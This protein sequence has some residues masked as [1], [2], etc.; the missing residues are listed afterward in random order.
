[1][2]RLATIS[3]FCFLFTQFLLGQNSKLSLGLVGSIDLNKYY[4]EDTGFDYEYNPDLGYSFGL[5]LQYFVFNKAFLNSGLSYISQGYM[6]KY[7]LIVMDPGDPAIPRESN[8]QVSF[9]NIPVTFGYTIVDVEKFRINPSVGI[10]FTFRIG[11]NESTVYEDDSERESDYLSQ[12]LSNTLIILKVSVG[13]EY[14]LN[15]RYKISF[16]PYFGK[17]LN[18]LDAESMKT[19]QLTYGSVFGFY[20][21]F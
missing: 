7:N 3:I 13:F 6:L 12:D 8:L 21:K 9:L 18:K 1:M 20:L 5:G 2:Q 15:E 10:D 19:G 4:F 17:G 14:H 11:D 16:T